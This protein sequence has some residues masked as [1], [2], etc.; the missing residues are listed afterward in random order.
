MTRGRLT[1]RG[2]AFVWGGLALVL[3]GSLL[4]YED[5]TR[6]GMLL[7]TLVG[8]VYLANLRKAPELTTVRSVQPEIVD[9]GAPAGVHLVLSNASRRRTRMMLAEEQVAYALGDRPRFAVPG[10]DRGAGRAVDYTVRSDRRGHHQLGPLIA[11]SSDP[12]GLTASE[13]VIA[14][15]KE[16]IVLPRITDLR[17]TQPPGSGAGTEGEIPQIIALHGEEDVSIR[18]YRDGDD[19][20]K[21]HWPATAHRG[22]L[23]VRQEDRPARRSCVVV[24]D[25]AFPHDNAGAAAFEWAVSAAAS[26][27]TRM[28]QL[29]Y[30]L[31]LATAETIQSEQVLRDLEVDEAMVTL[32][33]AEP[34]SDTDARSVFAAAQDQLRLG[35]VVVAILGDRP[36]G[37]ADVAGLRQP[38]AAGMAVIVDVHS[39][40]TG[41]GP[42]EGYVDD[43]VRTLAVA[44]WRTT[45]AHNARS[46]RQVWTDLSRRD[47]VRVGSL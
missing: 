29:G 42:A 27:S 40:R 12:F 26:I 41:S 11:R 9:N 2:R 16:V 6:V 7:L 46:V 4:G 37:A 24:L 3:A 28:T 14:G 8:V 22:E 34:G 32:A 20:R 19:L 36:G 47:L 39:Y 25:P 30:L 38:G 23:M 35:G 1:G 18:N 43:A 13:G 21:V 5:V 44:G 45:V 31:R 10:L 15:A 33:G 17:G